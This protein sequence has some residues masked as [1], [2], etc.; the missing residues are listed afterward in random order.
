M[1][2]QGA[3]LSTFVQIFCKCQNVWHPGSPVKKN[4]DA[5]TAPEL[6]QENSVQYLN[7]PV[8]D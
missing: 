8:P 4:T 3:L 7:T 6:E 5:V 1:D 2:V